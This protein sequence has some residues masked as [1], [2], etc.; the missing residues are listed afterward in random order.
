M[1]LTNAQGKQCTSE[2]MKWAL[3]TGAVEAD[4]NVTLTE[5]GTRVTGQRLR[6]NTKLQ[7]GRISGRSRVVMTGPP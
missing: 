1:V 2:H 6:G 5:D 3:D 7:K 4:G